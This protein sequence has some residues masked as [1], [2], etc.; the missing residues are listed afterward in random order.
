MYLLYSH[1]TLNRVLQATVFHQLV[2]ELHLERGAVERR[3]AN[4]TR[5]FQPLASVVK[6]YP[7]RIHDIIYE[8]CGVDFLYASRLRTD[9]IR[10]DPK[11][12]VG[13]LVPELCYSKSA[14]VAHHTEAE[15]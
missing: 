13:N 10:D 5:S 6:S 7:Q 9:S 2:Q 11:R 14:N 1:V 8:G 12:A 4:R 15:H 3:R